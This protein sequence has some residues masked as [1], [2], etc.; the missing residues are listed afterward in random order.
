[1]PFTKPSQRGGLCTSVH[2]IAAGWPRVEQPS[3]GKKGYFRRW[4]GRGFGWRR[5]LRNWNEGGCGLWGEK[6][7]L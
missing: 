6:G 2:G 3:G 1:M 4:N 7:N 5:G